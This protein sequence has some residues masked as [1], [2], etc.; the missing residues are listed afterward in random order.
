[1]DDSLKA[2]EEMLRRVSVVTNIPLRDVK[3]TWETIKGEMMKTLV[4][5]SEPI[6]FGFFA[7]HSTPYRDNWFNYILQRLPLLPA[8]IRGKSKAAREAHLAAIN[9]DGELMGPGLLAVSHRL[10]FFRLAVVPRKAWW[11]FMVAHQK[12]QLKILGP[13]KYCRYVGRVVAS[14]RPLH[15]YEYLSHLAQISLPCG[16]LS[17]SR[18]YG[19]GECLRSSTHKKSVRP[20]PN[21][22]AI[23]DI[24]I[25]RNP[26]ILQEPK[27]P[28]PTQGEAPGPV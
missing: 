1:M 13:V 5:T 4:E 15:T 6:D 23:P 18:Y 24:Q 20:S 8:A 21:P 7:L 27:G 12:H 25:S 11:R 14:L 10:A 17:N 22:V 28:H 19:G 9:W 2:T 16:A 26:N 3:F